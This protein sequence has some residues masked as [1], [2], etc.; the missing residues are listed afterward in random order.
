MKKFERIFQPMKL[1]NFTVRNRIEV[2]PAEP[3]L[4]TRDGLITPEFI[5]YTAEMARGGA[6]I[7]TVGDSPI[8]QA[9]AD[10]NH[11]VVNLADPFIVHGLVQLTEAIHRYGAL[12]SIELNLRDHRLPHDF[13]KAEMFQIIQDFADSAAQCRKGGFDMVMVHGGHGHT[14]AQF[15]SPHFNKRTDEYGAQN[16]ENRCRFAK[17]LLAAVREAIGPDMAIEYRISGD[18]LTDPGVHV[19]EAIQ[20]AKE[21]EDQIDMIHV[22]A[23]SLYDIGTIRYQIQPAYIPKA[24]NVRFA[25]EF[26]KHMNIPVT[27]VGSFDLDLAEEALTE[28]KA[29]MV[30]MIRAFVADPDL[31]NKAKAG[32]ADEI[33]PCIRCVICTG[34]DPHGCPKPL[35]CSVNPVAGRNLEFKTL[36]KAAV[37]KKVLVVG[38]GCGGMEAAR[39]LAEVGHQPILCERTDHLGG[40]LIEAA[41]CSLKTDI[42]RYRDWSIH[43]CEKDPRIEVRL[44][45][46][47][48]KEYVEAEK[49]DAVIIAVGSDPFVPPVPGFDRENVCLAT[50][51]DLGLKQVGHRVVCVGAGLTGTETAVA[52]AQEGHDVTLVDMLTIPQI[53]AKKQASNMITG[54][55]RIMQAQSGVKDITGVA[56]HE[57]NDEGLV[58]QHADGTLQTIPAD[59]I[60]LSM[61]V[62]P[63]QAIVDELK[64]IVP[65]TYVIGD[66]A[67]RAGNITSAV[68]D[69]FFAV[70]NM[71]ER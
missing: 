42:A 20:F 64:D 11:Y 67:T 61:G 19:D 1:R 4:C 40:T 29:D 55:I 37:P 45:T 21:I 41:A 62:R 8:N 47:V 12:A 14:V 39:R 33:R 3:F 9:Y 71:T 22:S 24:T 7:V 50:E 18:E 60:V 44:N 10:E 13:T 5:Q 35:R 34:D 32:R 43:M 59:N 16:F 57:V 31:V 52:L 65:E 27:T 58:V 23:G 51:V 56:A 38:G 17:E 48:T 46:T 26:K 28:G 6:G 30:A 69:A 53:D 66:C 2:S 54:T 36:P 15:F 70:M 63:R 25:A 49:P 68:R